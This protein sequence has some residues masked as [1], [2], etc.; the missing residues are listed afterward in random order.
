MTSLN[1][2]R[3]VA[4]RMGVFLFLVAL[5]L[6]WRANALRMDNVLTQKN[7]QLGYYEYLPALVV[8]QDWADLPYAI[9]LGFHRT[10]DIF[11]S[12]VAL[13]QAPFFGL[14]CA[15]AKI[16]GQPVDG[17]SPPFIFARFAASAFYMAAASVLLFLGL[18][19]NHPSRV[20]VL[21]PL[22]LF[23]A[24]NLYFYTLFD[25]GMSHVYA[26]ALFAWMYYLTVRM[27]EKPRSDRLV[28]LLV[29]AAWIIL[30]RPLNVLVLLFPLLYG[31]GPKEAIRQR[32]SW[33]VRYPWATLAGLALAMCVWLPQLLYWKHSTGSW[34]VF[35][36]GLDGQGFDWL[37]PH[38]LDVLVSHQNGWFVYT[39]LMALVMG[40]LLW[41]ALRN[42]PGA[43]LILAIWTLVWYSYASWWCWWLGG[44]FGF[45]G[46]VEYYALLALPLAWI[47]QR[48]IQQRRAVQEVAFIGIALLIFLNM[49][50]SQIYQWPWE[51]PTWN[52][53]SVG[54]AWVRALFG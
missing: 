33:V 44:G 50:I 43:R 11:T 41:G 21:V 29:V 7:D 14:A 5:V 17:Y 39:P 54:D 12:G 46:F 26:Y 48:L 23:G 8:P 51:G 40:T 32:I 25:P 24:T 35:T 49:R 52:W 37:H 2:A 20:A 34:L 45:R 18:R 9:S 47:L 30:V 36:Y 31:A 13:L 53:D 16:S 42:R 19:R 15:V 22:I 1:H 4:W 28:G 27:V 6:T 38:L 3:P 10:V